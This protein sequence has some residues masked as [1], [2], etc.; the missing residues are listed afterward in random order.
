MFRTHLLSIIRSFDTV[1]TANGICYTSYVDC[2]QARLRIKN[3]VEKECILL[4]PTIR[5]YQDARSSEYIRMHGPQNISGCTV[6]RIYQDARSSEY[7]RMHGL[8]NISGCTVLRIY[9][10]ARSS[11]CQIMKLIMLH[12]PPVHN[13]N[14]PTVMLLVI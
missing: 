1:F 9:Q 5:I 7:I 3:K 2:L 8:Q 10:D 12:N 14:T 13:N 11:E 6:L 4:A